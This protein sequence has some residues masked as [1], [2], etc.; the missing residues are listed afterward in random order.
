MEMQD[1]DPKDVLEVK[2]II[3]ILEAWRHVGGTVVRFRPIKEARQKILTSKTRARHPILLL[4]SEELIRD[5]SNKFFLFFSEEI[6]LFRMAS[7]VPPGLEHFSRLNQAIWFH[8]PNTVSSTEPA[9][10]LLVGWMDATPRHMAKYAAGYEKL[11]PSA[12]ILIITTTQID[13]AFRTHTAN[14]NRIK[15]ALN[16]LYTLPPS[17]KLLVHF[18][19]NGG[20]FTTTMIAKAYK[21]RMGRTLPVTAMILDSSPGRATY[22]AT[23]RAFSVALPNNIILRTIGNLILRIFFVLYKLGYLL[24][25]KMDLV[26]Q[27]RM[28]LNDKSIFDTDAP[29]MYIYSVADNMVAWQAVEEHG[30]EAQSLGYTIDREKF[31]ESGH[32]AHLLVDAD[33][34]WATVKR[35]WG[36]VS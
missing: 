29:R 36:S 13:A 18:F 26:D 28:D 8:Q 30:D 31:L 7:K 16:V 1:L 17:A 3:G 21:E 11:Y 6:V 15:P 27:A 9:L 2:D 32:A 22:E 10:I 34:Y 12:R 24:Q 14:L 5:V 20:G 19:S 4:T 25:G 23:V 35:L 33:R